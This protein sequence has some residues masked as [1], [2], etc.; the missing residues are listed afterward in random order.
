MRRQEHDWSAIDSAISSIA[1]HRQPS[2]AQPQVIPP[3]QPQ[4]P[5]MITIGGNRGRES[6]NSNDLSSRIDRALSDTVK[7]RAASQEPQRPWGLLDNLEVAATAV[8]EALQNWLPGLNQGIITDY[9]MAPNP[10]SGG[11][12]GKAADFGADIASGLMTGVGG[13]VLGGIPGLGVAG[14]GDQMGRN[15][16]EKRIEDMRQRVAADPSLSKQEADDQTWQ[17]GNITMDT[18]D[19]L[20]SGLAGLFYIGGGLVGRSALN[21]A[22]QKVADGAATPARALMQSAVPQLAYDAVTGGVHGIASEMNRANATPREAMRM[23]TDPETYSRA[24][25]EGAINAAVSLGGQAAMAR[26]DLD[27]LRGIRG[28]SQDDSNALPVEPDP[29]PVP[30]PGGLSESLR[31]MFT[32][33][34]A[35]KRIPVQAG[36]AVR[37]AM[38]GVGRAG[39]A[40]RN[41]LSEQLQRLVQPRAEEPA[42]QGSMQEP[43]STQKITPVPEDAAPQ[44]EV[45][46][47]GD[48]TIERVRGK[49]SLYAHPN[50]TVEQNGIPVRYELRELDDI[51]PS[52][53]PE[54]GFQPNPD[55]PQQI[56][57]RNYDSDVNEQ[58]KVK[59]FARN[60]SPS[61]LINENHGADD[62][63][64]I[65]DTEGNVMSGNGR[66]QVLREARSVHPE[67]FESY[68]AKLAQDASRFGFDPSDVAAMQ[69]PV[70]VRVADVGNDPDFSKR[71]LFGA[72][73]NDRTNQAQTPADVGS[74]LANSGKIPRDVVDNLMEAVD[75][76]R[77]SDALKSPDFLYPFRDAVGEAIPRE[78]GAM[79]EQDAAGRLRLNQYGQDVVKSMLLHHAI[80]DR[81]LT[82][83]VTSREAGLAD[84]IERAILPIMESQNLEAEGWALGQDLQDAIRMISENPRAK[85]AE[86][87]ITG[88]TGDIV[89]DLDAQAKAAGLNDKTKAL[90]RLLKSDPRKTTTLRKALTEYNAI[91]LDQAGMFA[92][93]NRTPGETLSALADELIT[94]TP[95]EGSTTVKDSENAGAVAARDFEESQIDNEG[96]SV[97][98][99]APSGATD[100][101]V[102]RT[103]APRR[104]RLAGTAYGLALQYNRALS[105]GEADVANAAFAALRKA[106]VDVEE[107]RPVP[108]DTV[109][110]LLLSR[111]MGEKAE[112]RRPEE[113]FLSEEPEGPST[114]R[115]GRHG[116]GDEI[117]THALEMPEV[118][119]LFRSLLG[120]V[121]KVVRGLG[122]RGMVKVPGKWRPH[123]TG[124]PPKGVEA[125]MEA[126][127]AGDTLQATRTL[128]HELFHV[129]DYIGGHADTLSRGGIARR[130]MS[131]S[132]TIKDAVSEMLRYK[133][134]H[135]D[136]RFGEKVLRDELWELSKSL[137]PIDESKASAR[138]IKYRKRGEEIYADFGS[139][140]IMNPRLVQEQA[141]RAYEAFFRF[142]DEKP[143]VR[144]AYES[145]METVGSGPDGV[146]TRRLEGLREGFAE[147]R[148]ARTEMQRKV[149]E[150]REGDTSISGLITKWFHD[151]KHDLNRFVEEDLGINR[152]SK[153]WARYKN[154]KDQSQGWGNQDHIYLG[155]IERTVDTRLKDNDLTTDDIGTMMAL[156]H[157]ME[158]RFRKDAESD[159]LR[160]IFNPRGI[161]PE[162]AES[163]MQ[164][165]RSDLGEARF[166][167]LERAAADARDLYFDHVINAAYKSGLIND[168]RYKLY[169]DRRDTYARFSVIKYIQER[170]G[171]DLKEQI[172]T[173]RDIENPYGATA[174][175][176]VALLRWAQQNNFRR[177]VAEP[178]LERGWPAA[179]KRVLME[180]VEEGQPAKPR[181]IFE[182]PATGEGK[183]LEFWKDGEKH[184]VILPTYAVDQLGNNLRT[185][186]SVHKSIQALAAANRPFRAMF[187]KYAPVFNYLTSW[188]RDIPESVRTLNIHGDVGRWEFTKDVLK[189][190]K[191]EMTWKEF[192]KAM[193]LQDADVSKSTPLLHARGGMNDEIRKAMDEAVL[194]PMNDSLIWSDGSYNVSNQ[195][196]QRFAETHNMVE[197]Q[198]ATYAQRMRQVADGVRLL[199]ATLKMIERLPQ[200]GEALNT[201]QKMAGREH[202]IKQGLD[203]EIVAQMTRDGIGNP[204]TKTKGSLTGF[205]DQVFLYTNVIEKSMARNFEAMRR[206]PKAFA[207]GMLKTGVAGATAMAAAAAGLFGDRMQDWVEGISEFDRS[208]YNCIPVP[209]FVT[210]DKHGR[211]QSHYIRLPMD[212]FSRI[213]HGLTW[214][215]S[216]AAVDL[217]RGG[218]VDAE[219]FLNDIFAMGESLSPGWSPIITIPSAMIDMAGG[220]NPY[221]E[222]RGRPAIDPDVFDAGGAEKYRQAFAWMLQKAGTHNF[223]K[224]NGGIPSIAGFDRVYRVSGRGWDEAEFDALKPERQ[225]AARKRLQS[226]QAWREFMESGDVTTIDDAETQ[227]TIT[228]RQA[229]G[230]RRKAEQTP[231]ERKAQG[232]TK[233]ARERA[234]NRSLQ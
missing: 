230:L 150:D 76:E 148:R 87:V 130:M 194:L 83:Y 22:A 31:Q 174:M 181:T 207:L 155:E 63:P 27:A 223:I 153:E 67:N 160:A 216:K 74:T 143:E 16:E 49:E 105:A 142:L 111:N 52:H 106:N 54:T 89:R 13:A 140:L 158:T 48:G 211:K 14:F 97:L 69:N 177:S 202:L 152:T 173:L 109:Q 224:F 119:D 71:A 6:N 70:L 21:R 35:A 10:T 43:V 12:W 231:F 86:E 113:G 34:E 147:G 23:L 124:Q 215:A 167:E 65:I 39:S 137:R 165:M 25:R 218:D 178:A 206:N 62:G 212:D 88:A 193:F 144:S 196:L 170:I 146:N 2:P 138:E 198:K 58:D 125:F 222:F 121:P 61:K 229:Q 132:K 122:A 114:A 227:G 85:T 104:P 225:E 20:D 214:K 9:E 51:R 191:G 26:G 195:A 38:E 98:M 169:H 162:A 73:A 50:E 168:D 7:Q 18:G 135:L 204:N 131:D 45:I 159:E 123:E 1:Q 108:Q 82:K 95:K 116:Q 166:S 182:Q 139:A 151:S 120:D 96:S 100:D 32:I 221:D 217:S 126:A 41:S 37:G 107:G 188:Y 157:I 101:R 8:P 180:Q 3:T 183:V 186:Q 17:S 226:R 189:H 201:A 149:Q 90:I 232:L 64:P 208:N 205:L 234:L 133:F 59:Q 80:G 29:E 233:E 219:G 84:R 81:S 66:T 72:R 175:Q 209:P 164:K 5:Q 94:V 15:W 172:G 30:S 102:T 228:S 110:Q 115:V 44:R 203:P 53:F 36:R 92:D 192:G 127:T 46:T 190:L 145:M 40:A 57:N 136:P 68:K 179:K 161:T 78:S 213:A 197:P 42:A 220:Q 93:P 156:Q 19:Y 200:I 141:P 4:Q 117:E 11:A 187:T 185:D 171:A 163:M 99:D 210:V 75:G 134:H 128:A 47:R 176:G 24:L 112:Q 77:V 154:I 56:Q 28:A 60:L 33:P 129:I 91:A 103:G 199:R 55:Y 118:V 184:G 79:F